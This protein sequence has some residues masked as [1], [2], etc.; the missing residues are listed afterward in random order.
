MLTQLHVR[1]KQF[2]GS[3]VSVQK[4]K[5]EDDGL[6]G[7]HINTIVRGSAL[8]VKIFKKNMSLYFVIII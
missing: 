3:V 1:N 7:R 6:K 8:V 5:E 2:P 4:E